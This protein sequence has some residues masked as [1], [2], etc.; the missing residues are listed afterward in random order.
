MPRPATPRGRRLRA[1]DER[2]RFGEAHSR[3]GFAGQPREGEVEAGHVVLRPSAEGPPI[4]LQHRRGRVVAHA[5]V[6]HHPRRR[7]GGGGMVGGG[8]V[9]GAAQRRN[10]PIP[11]IIGAV[12]YRPQMAAVH[13]LPDNNLL[14][15]CARQCLLGR[16]GPPLLRVV[17]HPV[18]HD[19]RGGE[20]QQ[21]RPAAPPLDLRDDHL[22]LLV[23]EVTA[24]EVLQPVGHIGPVDD[25]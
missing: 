19:I 18:L 8:V 24:D 11:I 22:H 2:R 14:R 12:R 20:H 5:V 6:G 4:Q 1:H 17:G 21:R 9:A 23:R 13:P 3:L 10:H 7:L 25:V 16:L 15:R